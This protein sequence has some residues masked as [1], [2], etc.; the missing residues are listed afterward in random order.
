MAIKSRCCLGPPCS[1]HQAQLLNTLTI[2]RLIDEPE[3]HTVPTRYE[4]AID[5]SRRLRAELAA[6]LDESRRLLGR[7]AQGH[8]ERNADEW[9]RL[10]PI[11]DR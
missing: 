2:A 1:S 11:K 7:I 9:A 10:W 4:A 3:R 5:E 8:A 6:T